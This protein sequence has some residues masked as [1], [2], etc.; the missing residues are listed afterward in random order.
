MHDS[1]KLLMSIYHNMEF[2]GINFSHVTTKN[3][4]NYKEKKQVTIT[5]K[6][7]HPKTRCLYREG[8]TMGK[9]PFEA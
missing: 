5:P 6:L 9:K 7:K 8:I 3:N 1:Y 2:L 4:I